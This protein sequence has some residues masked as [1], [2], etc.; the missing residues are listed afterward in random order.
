MLITWN[1]DYK[2]VPHVN[3]CIKRIIPNPNP[4]CVSSVE[5]VTIPSSVSY[6]QEKISDDWLGNY[7]IEFV[8]TNSVDRDLFLSAIN[9][10]KTPNARTVEITG[11]PLFYIWE[12][13]WWSLNIVSPTAFQIW[14][15]FEAWVSDTPTALI[16]P[17]IDS[18]SDWDYQSS[19][20][21]IKWYYDSLPLNTPTSTWG[22]DIT[23]T[24]TFYSNDA[25]TSGTIE[26]IPSKQV[27]MVNAD[28]SYN[29]KYYLQWDM[30]TEVLLDNSTDI[31]SCECSEPQVLPLSECSSVSL[32]T[33]IFE[34]TAYNFQ[35]LTQNL[36]APYVYNFEDRSSNTSNWLIID[37]NTADFTTPD[38][39]TLYAS[40]SDWSQLTSFT[41]NLSN[42]TAAWISPTWSFAWDPT[43][44]SFIADFVSDLSNALTSLWLSTPISI[45][46]FDVNAS[47]WWLNFTVNVIWTEWTSQP[48][49]LQYITTTLNWSEYFQQLNIQLES[50]VSFDLSSLTS[51]PTSLVLKVTANIPVWWF[52]VL[53][54]YINWIYGNAPQPYTQISWTWVMSDYYY[55]FPI[56]WIDP[57]SWSYT[58][59]LSDVISNTTWWL[60]IEGNNVWDQVFIDWFELSATYAFWN[61]TSLSVSTIWC[62]DD[63]RDGKLDEIINALDETLYTTSF[64]SEINTDLTS[65]TPSAPTGTKQVDITNDSWGYIT[66]YTSIWNSIVAP[67]RVL[68]ISVDDNE[69]DI[70]ITGTSWVWSYIVWENIVFNY[71]MRN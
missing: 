20:A 48:T 55:S 23:F 35:W 50:D 14:V 2:F 37:T 49:Y 4:S 57:I 16:S 40:I 33:S 30:S 8:F 67:W 10:I 5:S 26:Y 71:R 59:S 52:A 69:S 58:T 44:A 21:M 56:S 53:W 62:N 63:R 46:T 43:G 54:L 22:S 65:S 7:I 32:A 15:H 13:N 31:F 28:G 12:W 17:C 39:L 34:P 1:K 42:T 6:T 68:S 47:A 3:W 24:T 18:V 36:W 29:E 70:N 25:L 60:Y 27:V 51:D 66:I 11:G 38:W 41:D 19:A 64:S 45:D 9:N 61:E